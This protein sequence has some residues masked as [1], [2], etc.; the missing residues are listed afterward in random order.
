MKKTKTRKTFPIGQLVTPLLFATLNGIAWAVLVRKIMVDAGVFQLAMLYVFFTLIIL[1]FLLVWSWRKQ[2][3]AQVLL[4]AIPEARLR[5]EHQKLREN[6]AAAN[7]SANHSAVYSADG[8][9]TRDAR[10]EARVY[11]AAQKLRAATQAL[12]DLGIDLN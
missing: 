1:P 4:R 8:T 10:K 5:D 9:I 2:F 3:N 11:D 7:S 6:L 12:K